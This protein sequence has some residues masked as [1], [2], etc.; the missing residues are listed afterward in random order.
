M[1]LLTHHKNKLKTIEWTSYVW[2]AYLPYTIAA[3]IPVKSWHDWFWLMLVGGFLVLYI[4]VVEKPNWRAVTMPAELVVTGLFAVFAANNFMIIFP[5][6]QVSFLLGRRPKR[7]FY[8]FAL[9]YYAF[10][11]GGCI[12]DYLQYPGVFGW[13]NGDV[14]GL[15]FPLLSPILAYTFSRSVER[16]RQ[17]NQTNRRLKTIV[18]RNERER[19]ARDLHDTLG[20]SFSM[21]TLKT[22]L[23]KK[24]LVKAPEKVA[25]ELDEIE[26]TSRQNL[27]LV[28][29]IVN[30]LHEQS[31]TEVLLA[32][33]RNL[34]VVGVWTTT[35][36]ETQ[37]TKW[38][39]TVQ[40]CFAAVLVEAMTNVMRHA[41]A[42]EVRIDFVETAKIYQIKLKDDGKGGTLIRQG[43]NGIAGMRTRLQAKQGTFAI[44]SSRRGTQLILTLPKE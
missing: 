12:R 5:G 20:Q 38:P 43:A 32:Q 23:A 33:T 16:Q 8:G 14:M 24:L 30:N 18:E 17:L 35:T 2:L 44:T 13:H 31:L 22:E 25:P 4:L 9:G 28:R 7:E 42:H 39:T 19:I 34:A 37:A 6:W 36:G 3:Y 41:H 40:S 21:I 10:L 11:I 26:Q 15:V 27:Q 29:E 1:A